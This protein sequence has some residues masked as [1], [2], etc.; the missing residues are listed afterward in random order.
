M[1]YSIVARD[2]RSGQLGVAVQTC[3]L[4]VGTWVPWAEAGVG[5]V[6]TQASAERSYGALGLNLMRGRMS[7]RRALDALSA[8]DDRLEFRQVAFV[9]AQGEVAVHTGRRCLPEA[10]HVSGEAFATQA[11]MMAGDTVWREMARAYDSHGGDFADRLLAALD[12]AELAG[13]D[14]RGRQ[15]AAL[16]VVGPDESTFPLIDLRVDHHPEPLIELRRLLDLHRA[17]SA[18]Y[19]AG[20]AAKAGDVAR[21]SQLLQ[22]IARW[23]PDE[24]YLQ[25]LRALHL[26]ATLDRWDE[27]VKI[28]QGLIEGAPIW[29]E[30]LRRD[31]SVGHS[32]NSDVGPRLLRL[33]DRDEDADG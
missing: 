2:T 18:E 19:A 17:Y 16:L 8:A 28:L 25:Y 24:G 22:Q 31:A 33:L 1:T 20:E 9:D 4:A 10:G 6:A 5:A 12:A 23:A 21:V 30:Y 11:N 27:A 15:T 29:E 14:I 32:D 13:G 3:N 26:A 7:A